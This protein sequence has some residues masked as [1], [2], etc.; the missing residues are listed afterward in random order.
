MSDD[1]VP[2]RGLAARGNDRWTV[3][4]ALFLVLS[5]I[6]AAVREAA[7][8]IN[9]PDAWW[10]LR[11]GNDL[12]RQQSLSA[13]D[14]W[15]PRATVEWA[16]SEPLPEIVAARLEHAGGLPA[17]AWLYG[18]AAVVVVLCVY[19][20]CRRGSGIL[21]AS[22]CTVL[23][24][25]AMWGSLTPRP[26]MVS[27]VLLIVVPIAW[28]RA[29]S[30]LRAPWWLVPLTWFWSMCHGFWV[31]GV[32]LSGLCW[33]GLVLDRR[34]PWRGAARL[35]LVPV[36]S[37]AVVALN[38]A[39]WH[40]L[41]APLTVSDTTRYIAEWDRTAYKNASG[42]VCA[43]LLVAVLACLVRKRRDV[44][45]TDVLL[46]A[47]AVFFWWY[48][49]RTVAVAGLLA[50]PVLAR[51]IQEVLPGPRPGVLSRHRETVTLGGGAALA[52]VVLALVVPRTS[53]DPGGVPLALSDELDRLPA[54]SSV[55]NAYGWGGWL[56]WRHP[57]LDRTSDG[58]VV[59][60]DPDYIGNLRDIEVAEGEWLDLVEDVE[61]DYALLPAGTETVAGLADAGWHDVARADGAVL[62]VAPATD[63]SP[64]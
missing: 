53:S 30:S 7:G 29:G 62:L 55:L 15:S 20:A 41:L 61:V 3:W 42:V 49:L 35:A 56:A 27:F 33:L 43:L 39:G 6:A 58:L 14:D 19:G 17:L 40:V 28:E 63:G 16:P 18:F 59:P 26:Q 50:A 34:P 11:L 36:A 38:P 64:G 57:A 2:A 13:P 10:H 21:V 9:D 51:L 47:A 37:V 45:W 25:A 46:L 22:V 23:A 4:V 60:Y 54:G 48:A 12:W 52:L 24:T 32:A 8:P 5:V 31:L 44:S 1:G